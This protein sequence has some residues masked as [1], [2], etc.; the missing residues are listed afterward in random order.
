MQKTNKTKQ[1]PLQ[2]LTLQSKNLNI[3]V[4]GAKI[5]YNVTNKHLHVYAIGKTHKKKTK[6]HFSNDD[7]NQTSDWVPAII[8]T[9]QS[10]MLCHWKPIS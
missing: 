4:S 7:T 8:K 2:P 5:N 10:T 9:L 3:P 1:P 6:H